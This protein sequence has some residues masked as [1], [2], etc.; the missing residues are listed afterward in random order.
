MQ[1]NSGCPLRAKSGHRHLFDH[2]VS[3]QLHRVGDRESERLGSSETDDEL[4]LMTSGTDISVLC[5]EF[6]DGLTEVPAEN[7]V[8]P[9]RR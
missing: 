4:E 9:A 7:S 8:G 2:P 5:H 1:C 6:T 3:E